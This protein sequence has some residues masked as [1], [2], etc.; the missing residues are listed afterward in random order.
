MGPHPRRETT[1][2]DKEEIWADNVESKHRHRERRAVRVRPRRASDTIVLGHPNGPTP[3]HTAPGP[4]ETLPVKFSTDGGGPSS[5]YVVYDA[6]RV[7]ELNRGLAGDVRGSSANGLTSEFIGD[8]NYAVA[9]N[10]Q[11]AAVWN[12]V[13]NAAD[14]PAVDAFRQAIVDGA[15]PGPHLGATAPQGSATPT[16]SGVYTPIPRRDRDALAARRSR[17]AA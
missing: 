4:N 13:R 5:V 16:S 15:L 10:D 11:G 3:S 2:S 6:A 14:C 8:Y 7:S 9:T 1:F 12:D 17:R